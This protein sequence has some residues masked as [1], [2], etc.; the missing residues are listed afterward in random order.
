MFGTLHRMSLTEF[1]IQLGLYDVEFTQTIVYDDLLISR[2]IGESQEDACKR[3]SIDPTYDP[4]WSKAMTL[5]SPALRY[6]CIS[7]LATQPQAEETVQASSTEETDFLLSMLDGFQ[8]HLGHKV[9]ISIAH[10]GT[11]SPI[12]SFFVSLYIT[13]WI[14]GWAFSWGPIV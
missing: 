6:I 4:R 2:P 10:H 13:K 7:S 1:S 5:R 14:R 9:A 12:R 11:D 8:M 3:F